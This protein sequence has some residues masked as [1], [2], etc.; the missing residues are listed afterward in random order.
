MNFKILFQSKKIV[1]IHKPSGFLTYE[2]TDS[3]RKISCKF[4][5]EHQLKK[6]IYPVHRIDKD[7]CGIL[8]YSLDPRETEKIQNLFKERRIKKTYLAIVHGSIGDRKKIASSLIHPKSK[9]AEEA[10]TLLRELST[11]KIILNN[12]E[13]V[14]S[15]VECKPLT[16]RHHQIRRH[17]KEIECPIVGDQ[18]YGN[19]WE[20]STFEKLYQLNRTLLSAVKLEISKDVHIKTKPDEAFLKIL[21]VLGLSLR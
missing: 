2:N 17:L 10:E 14:Y 15:L 21:K 1:A 11:A 13:R 3:Q 9:K 6:K 12:E 5:L 4:F 18:E 7:T 20:N 16:G 8:C 19:S